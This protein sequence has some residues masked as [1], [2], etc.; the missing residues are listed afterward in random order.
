MAGKEVHLP[1]NPAGQLKD[2]LPS[3]ISQAEFSSAICDFFGKFGVVALHKLYCDHNAVPWRPFIY[4]VVEFAVLWRS[5]VEAEY[6][7]SADETD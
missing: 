5:R 3:F 6:W 2:L 4:S 1:R 7:I